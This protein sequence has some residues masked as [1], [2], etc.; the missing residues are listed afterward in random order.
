MGSSLGTNVA[1][2]INSMWRGILP[3]KLEGELRGCPAWPPVP[4]FICRVY[5]GS[6]I[7]LDS[8][9]NF[10][11]ERDFVLPVVSALGKFAMDSL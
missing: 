5:L 2:E 1:V 11:S 6:L 8:T 4:H 9:E 10:C 3:H 7:L